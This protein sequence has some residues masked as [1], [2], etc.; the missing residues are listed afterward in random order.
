MEN[1]AARVKNTSSQPIPLTPY[2][3]KD[4]G[5]VFEIKLVAT[6]VCLQNGTA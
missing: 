2:I 4:Q 1:L 3:F 6:A 5:N